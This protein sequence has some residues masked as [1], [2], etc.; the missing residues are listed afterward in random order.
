MTRLALI[1]GLATLAA[2]APQGPELNPMEA[3][4]AEIVRG[5]FRALETGD[6]AYLNK[7]FDPEGR[8]YLGLEAR[9]RGGPFNTFAEAAAFPGA[10]ENVDVTVEE[11]ITEGDRVATQSVICG[12]HTKGPILGTP[13]TG[14]RICARYINV[15]ELADGRITSN[16]VSVYADQ[17]RNQLRGETAAEGPTP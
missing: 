4:N 11:L 1:C 14:K 2:C 13:P 16:S 10:L 15:Y 8:V 5:V 17:I 9:T 3:R 6:L 7:V 12:D